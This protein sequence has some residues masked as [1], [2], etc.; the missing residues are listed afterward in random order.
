MN[1]EEILESLDAVSMSIRD[2]I[3]EI[4][5]SSNSTSDELAEIVNY[6]H[7]LKANASDLLEEA[8]L[9]LVKK[10]NYT[11]QPIKVRGAT[12]EIKQG[13]PRKSWD[14]RA[15]ADEVSRR[16]VDKSIDL[17]TGE[18]TKSPEDMMHELLKYAAVSYWRVS[19]LNN[20][21][22]D[23]NDYCEVGESKKSVI[24]R[25]EQ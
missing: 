23:A 22:I 13:A 16:I 20:L 11:A 21:N 10:V 17:D 5:Q 1:A 3:N 24:V 18:I 14:H 15:L 4:N 2:L 25:R 9:S 12:V 8:Q 7:S 6:A 19:E